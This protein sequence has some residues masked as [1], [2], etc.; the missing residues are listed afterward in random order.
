LPEPSS[1]WPNYVLRAF[2]SWSLRVLNSG[3]PRLQDARMKK[4]AQMKRFLSTVAIILI[5]FQVFLVGEEQKKLLPPDVVE[6]EKRIDA[7]VPDAQYRDDP[8]ILVAVQEA[9]LGL[10][11]NNGGVGACL[12]EE[13][14]GKIVERGH[15]RQFNPY[16]RSDL[17]AEMDLL[18]RYEDRVKALRSNDA[19]VPQ[20]VQ[21]KVEG[22]VLYTSVE[23][24]PMCL[25]RIINI[26]LGKTYYA[27]P[28][29]TGGMA[30]KLSDLPTFWQDLGAGHVFEQARCSPDLIAIAKAL[31][32]PMSKK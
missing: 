12:V 25:S 23:P 22:L 18:N 6:L 8:F 14:T 3:T 11:E 5:L 30:H 24:C 32:R 10:K 16:F 9:L 31:F 28:D 13:S 26:R 29:P 21:R 20:S 15:N 1:S 4:S 2:E 27:A 19:S 17:H 7:F